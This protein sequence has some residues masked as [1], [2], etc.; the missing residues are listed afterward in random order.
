[1]RLLQ[2]G[3]GAAFLLSCAVTGMQGAA[4]GGDSRP[5]SSGGGGGRAVGDGWPAD[6]LGHGP[7]DSSAAVSKA[8][9]L[10]DL[11][12]LVPLILNRPLG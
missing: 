4:R 7:A 5:E 10:C 1:M 2:E 9:L 11:A 3:P 6:A 8:I 12:P